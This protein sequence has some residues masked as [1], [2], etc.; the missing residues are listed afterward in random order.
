MVAN[1][2][3][4]IG[5]IIL[6]GWGIAHI[7]AA[8]AVVKGFG[9]ISEDN[10]KFILMEWVAEGLTLCFIGV[11]V[12]LIN[13]LGGTAN[14]VSRIVF[15]IAAGMLII[16][17]AWTAVTGARTSNVPT[18]ICPYVLTVVTILFLIASFI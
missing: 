3:I 8:K 10:K 14:D 12:L 7:I 17:A 16:M 11:L 2:L 15:R 13:I 9:A 6:L 1:L 18:K 4:Y 5:A